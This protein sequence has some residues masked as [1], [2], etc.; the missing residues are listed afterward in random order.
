MIELGQYNTLRVAR[1]TPVGI[2]LE[3]DEENDVL[4]HGKFIPEGGLKE[5]D[6][7]EVFIY[8][9]NEGRDIATTQTPKI[10]VEEFALLEVTSIDKYGAFVDIGLDKELLVPF[11]EQAYKMEVGKSYLVFMYVD[12]LSDRLAGSTKLEQFLDNEEIELEEGAEVDVIFWKQTDLGYKVIVNDEHIGLVYA[13]ELFSKPQAGTRTTGYVR[14]V[15]EDNKLDIRLQK[16]GYE[17]IEPTAQKILELLQKEDGFVP[18]TDKSSP[19]AIKKW[20]GISKKMFKKSIGNLYKQKLILLE[21]EGI[22]LVK[23]A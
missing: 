4:L 17:Q 11:M 16:D 8:K 19:E 21:V 10:I 1:D 12:G 9:D 22:R 14:K 3:D 13:N 20:L 18:L 15:R 2:F 5:G 23:K 7:I 6:E